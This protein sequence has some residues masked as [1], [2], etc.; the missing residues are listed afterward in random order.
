M[1]TQQGG[2]SSPNTQA[3]YRETTQ[4]PPSPF[5]QSTFQYS[6]V[7]TTSPS[8]HSQ[9]CS[10]STLQNAR[11]NENGAKSS[12]ARPPILKHHSFPKLI[13]NY[14]ASRGHL[15][16]YSSAAVQNG[17]NDEFLVSDSSKMVIICSPTKSP[18][19]MLRI[20]DVSAHSCQSKMKG[21]RVRICSDCTPV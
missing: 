1:E 5:V 15:V 14:P 2:C 4:G 19:K 11:E 10:T 3:N 16:K 7:K 12:K 21:A 20:I 17:E 9:K 6:S 13:N 18:D 8:L